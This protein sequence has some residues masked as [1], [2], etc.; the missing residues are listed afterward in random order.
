M[1][2]LRLFILK[3]EIRNI[4]S[5]FDQFEKLENQIV[6]T[7]VSLVRLFVTF[8]LF[9]YP[10]L[11]R[12]GYTVAKFG[13]SYLSLMRSSTSVVNM[14]FSPNDVLRCNE[15]CN[16]AIQAGLEPTIFAFEEQKQNGRVPTVLLFANAHSF[17]I[18]HA[19]RFPLVSMLSF[20]FF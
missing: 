5:N 8:I 18:L 15:L 17:C 12:V 6:E 7:V 14:S 10:S 9:I 2:S 4:L 3:K 20:L 19:K 16:M 11:E 13:S 1:R